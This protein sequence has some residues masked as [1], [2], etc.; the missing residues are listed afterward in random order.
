MLMVFRQAVEVG[1]QGSPQFAVVLDIQYV[2]KKL[3]VELTLPRKPTTRVTANL[4]LLGR[5]QLD[6]HLV[7]DREFEPT[8]VRRDIPVHESAL[9][10]KLMVEERFEQVYTR[11][12]LAR[13]CPH[14]GQFPYVHLPV[15]DDIASGAR[16]V[17]AYPSSDTVN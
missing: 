10:I 5:H 11:K 3:E 8:W 13:P 6:M 7:G 15:R 4:N 1:L 2:I 12:I 17:S 16:K 9:S 14:I